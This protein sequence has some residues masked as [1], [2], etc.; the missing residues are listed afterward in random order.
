MAKQKKWSIIDFIDLENI[1]TAVDEPYLLNCVLIYHY[2][3][4]HSLEKY[5]R[6]GHYY[7]EGTGPSCLNYADL[8]ITYFCGAIL[9]SI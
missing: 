7:F 2:S 6:K 1:P 9:S 3:H 4:R 5:I 8:A